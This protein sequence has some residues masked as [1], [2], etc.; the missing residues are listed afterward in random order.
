MANAGELLTEEQRASGG[1]AVVGFRPQITSKKWLRVG[2]L[3]SLLTS[4]PAFAATFE[5]LDVQVAESA[6]NST[7]VSESQGSVELTVARTGS[8]VGDASVQWATAADSAESGTDF[9]A[10][11]GTLMWLDGDTATRTIAI[12]LVS[13]LDI[14]GVESFSVKL[15]KPLGG[16]IG[17]VAEASIDITDAGQDLAS[18]AGLS[19]K[20]MELDNTEQVS[21][22]IDALSGD[23]LITAAT[24]TLK[25]LGSQHNTFRNRLTGLRAGNTN[26]LDV[27]RL[28]V[29]VDG[30]VLNGAVLDEILG[31]LAGAEGRGDDL[32]RLN[33]YV[34]GNVHFGSKDRDS[35]NGGYKFDAQTLTIG[36]DY[37]LKEN[38]LVGAAAGF[39]AGDVNFAEGGSLAVDSW[40]SSLY[41]S[42]FN[43]KSFFL[44]GQMSYGK[45]TYDS[46]RRVNY[47]FA[48]GSVDRTATGNTRGSQ[49]TSGLSSGFGWKR[50]RLAFEPIVALSYSNVNVDSYVEQGAGGLNLDIGQQ[51]QQSLAFSGGARASYEL[52]T[53]IGVLTPNARIDHVHELL[54]STQF[55][56][57]GFVSSPDGSDGSEGVSGEAIQVAAEKIDKDYLLWSVGTSSKFTKSFSGY[58]NYQSTLKYTGVDLHQL[59][60][61]LRFE[62][63]Y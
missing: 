49:F 6:G 1:D 38:Y 23:E 37:R 39:E 9:I 40:K 33:Y 36:A 3:I 48:G 32:Q 19:A 29:E 58:V 15:F 2:S 51:L 17:D 56:S 42:Y 14:E 59:T 44:D 18:T 63:K 43:D 62:R 24:S 52:D 54:D 46:S 7:S 55:T 30:E 10:G 8:G 35:A 53:K 57:V 60:Y 28:S 50:G 22:A 5:F 47:D 21:E 27:S 25:L 34:N 20:E 31:S 13:D 4:A 11:S 45:N 41:G 16:T 26:T 61:G 12:K